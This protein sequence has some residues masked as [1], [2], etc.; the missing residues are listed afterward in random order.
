VKARALLRYL[1][2]RLRLHQDHQG[3][4]QQARLLKA[5]PRLWLVGSMIFSS[6]S[7]WKENRSG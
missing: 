3:R 4:Q 5:R 1:S 6:C 2:M 7:C